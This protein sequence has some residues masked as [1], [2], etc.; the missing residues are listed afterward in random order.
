MAAPAHDTESSGVAS[1]GID[2]AR[3][4]I[5]AKDAGVF[6]PGVSGRR[7]LHG[8][9]QLGDR[10]RGR[11]GVWLHA[12]D[13][14]FAVELDGD[15]APDALRATRY[16]HPTRPRSSLSRSLFGADFVRALDYLRAGDLRVR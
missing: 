13:H 8:P 14:H 1:H 16:C 10:S 3:R 7:R 9:G 12:A 11:L 6:R 15:L 5:L 4:G 2:R